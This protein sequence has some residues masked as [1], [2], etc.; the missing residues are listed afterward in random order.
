MF[1]RRRIAGGPEGHAGE[2]NQSRQRGHGDAS[3]CWQSWGSQRTCKYQTG[4]S[5]IY[6]NDAGRSL[7]FQDDGTGSGIVAVDAGGS[8]PRG[9]NG[10]APSFGSP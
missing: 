2:C 10:L 8:W 9:V 4:Q 7:R 5:T 1:H 3:S 6:V